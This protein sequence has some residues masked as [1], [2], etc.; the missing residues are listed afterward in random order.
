M[1]STLCAYF[2]DLV[3]RTDFRTCPPMYWTN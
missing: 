2:M 1:I 3:Q